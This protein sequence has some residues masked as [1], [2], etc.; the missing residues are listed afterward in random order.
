[1]GVLVVLPTYNEAENIDRVLRH[2]RRAM[3]E[4]G[5]LVVDD[6]S[7]DGTGHMAEQLAKELDGIEV[8]H[9][10]SKSG[11]GSAYRAGFAWGLERGWDVLIEMDADLSH[12]PDSL[13]ALVAPLGDG[14][15]LVVGSRYVPGGSIPNWKWHRRLLSRAGNIYA[16]VLLGLHIT[17]STSGYRAYSAGILRRLTLDSVRAEGYGFQIEM[18]YEVIRQGGR[19]TE[20]PICFVDRLEGKSKMSMYIVI[21]A[22]AL[23]TWWSLR[24]MADRLVPSRAAKRDPVRV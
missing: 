13:P 19:V 21:E 5:V 16:A 6:G 3:P 23:V 2:I 11:L 12:N 14:Y 24:R 22:L 15:D 7:A 20:V 17:D 18:V 9:R 8:L 1:M 4:A 10:T